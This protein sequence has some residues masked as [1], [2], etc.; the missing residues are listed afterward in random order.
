M[1]SCLGLIVATVILL[2][3]I[4]TG[5]GVWYL[6]HTTEFERAGAPA[7]ADNR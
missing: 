2:G 3:T 6:S 5:L 1:K 7:K 4:A